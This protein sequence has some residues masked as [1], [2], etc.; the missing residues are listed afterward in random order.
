[1]GK[2]RC[3]DS[4][5]PGAQYNRDCAASCQDHQDVLKAFTFK[6]DNPKRPQQ[7]QGKGM[8]GK[9]GCQWTEVSYINS[10]NMLFF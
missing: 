7:M 1:M 6:A 9:S 10:Q 5:N 8:K 3:H 2:F 4:K